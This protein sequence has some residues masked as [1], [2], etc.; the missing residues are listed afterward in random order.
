LIKYLNLEHGLTVVMVLH[1]LNQAAR[2]AGRV[3]VLKDGNVF[4]EGT[5]ADVLTPA[6]LAEVFGVRARV[7]DGPDGIELVIVPVGRVDNG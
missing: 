7:M 1:D 6:T 5:P 4:A 3:V 2:Y